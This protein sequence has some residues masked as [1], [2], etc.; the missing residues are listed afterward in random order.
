MVLLSDVT[1]TQITFTDQSGNYVFNY[2][3]SVSH[4]VRITPSKS[5]YAFEPLWAAFVSSVGLTGNQTASFAGTPSSSPS[6]EQMPILL[7][8]ES[9]LSALALDSVT[10]ISEPFG[11]TGTNNFSTDQRTRVSLFAVNVELGAGETS[12]VITAQAED[13]VGQ[14][15]PLTIE[16]FGAVPNFGWL[17][18]VVVKLP[19]EIAG[20]VEVRVSLKLRGTAG[21]K[22]I[23]KVY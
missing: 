8:Q 17:K 2:A 12:S 22:A 15:F 21:N 7:T 14:I 10:M 13:S 20:S 16:Y 4:S 5:G 1:G 9:S 23:V 6:S 11:I 19:A 18:Q 3:G